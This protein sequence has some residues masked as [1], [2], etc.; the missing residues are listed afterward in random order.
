[1]GQDFFIANPGTYLVFSGR[2]FTTFKN[3]IEKNV[4]NLVSHP[5]SGTCTF[6]GSRFKPGAKVE[7]MNRRKKLTCDIVNLDLGAQIQQLFKT[8]HVLQLKGRKDMKRIT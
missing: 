4:K 8:L 7:F 1:L 3:K 5:R 6:G 2:T